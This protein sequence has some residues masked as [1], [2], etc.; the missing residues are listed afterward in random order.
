VIEVD[1]SHLSTKFEDWIEK[2]LLKLSTLD[3][4]QVEIKDYS[5]ELVR[6]VT[7]E[8]RPGISVVWDPRSEMTLAYND[9]DSSWSPVRLRRFNSATHEDFSLAEDEELNKTALDGL[10]TALDDL[11]IVDVERKPQGLSQDLKAGVDFLNNLEAQANLMARGFAPA[12]RGGSEQEIISSDGEVVVTMKNGTEYVLRFGNLVQVDD[13][14]QP[15]GDAAGDDASKTGNTAQAGIH[16]YLFA[17]ARFD[18]AAVKKPEL[19]DLPALPEGAQ[20]NETP[21][22]DDAQ[23]GTSEEDDNDDG[24]PSSTDGEPGDKPPQV[25]GDAET[26]AEQAETAQ[27]DEAAGADETKN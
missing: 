14:G 5:A 9:R 13:G 6:G 25:T 16:R 11:K 17:M 12:S 18:E 19:Q 4:Q 3:L 21:D 7:P 26:P 20:I 8:G 15:S 27:Q 1:P 10:K 2:D 24:E 22:S 23:S